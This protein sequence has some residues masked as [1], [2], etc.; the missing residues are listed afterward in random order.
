MTCL[1]LHSLVK[2][3]LSL[4]FPFPTPLLHQAASLLDQ[5]RFSHQLWVCSRSGCLC[6]KRNVTMSFNPDISHI[7]TWN[8][9]ETG[10]VALG[11]LAG[12][13]A[14]SLGYRQATCSCCN[15]VVCGDILILI[16]ELGTQFQPQLNSGNLFLVLCYTWSR[17]FYIFFKN[18]KQRVTSTNGWGRHFWL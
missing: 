7:L 15:P 18:L 12:G 3:K 16:L 4:Y 8:S 14:S 2:P 5:E 1:R 9:Q 13:S 10:T 11:P 17:N 6:D